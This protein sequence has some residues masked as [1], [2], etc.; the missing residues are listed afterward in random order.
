MLH[1]AIFEYYHKDINYEGKNHF[2]CLILKDSIYIGDTDS[3]KIIRKNIKCDILNKLINNNNEY[4][5]KENDF[6]RIN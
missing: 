5:Y 1:M 6:S 4:Q 3:L 2:S